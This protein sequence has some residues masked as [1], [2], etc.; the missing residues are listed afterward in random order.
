[1]FTEPTTETQFPGAHTTETPPIAL[2]RAV[3]Y[4]RVSSKGQ[5]DTDYDP[6]GISLPA[7]RAACMRKAEQLGLTVVDEYVEPGKSGTEI[8]KRIAFQT[9]LER[10]RTEKDVDTIVMASLKKRGVTLVSV[11]EN[12]DDSPVGQLMHGI[13]PAFN[14]YRSLEDGAD[15][16]YKMGEKAKKGGTIGAAPLGYLNV[17]ERF[18]GREVRT[19]ALDPE[20]APL[21]KQTF[22]LYATGDYT[23][24]ELCAEMADRAC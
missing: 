15:I 20:R 3:L 16:A 24:D 23:S 6:E 17:V 4:L 22:E 8:S 1:M 12:I 18:E 13:L 19:V 21:I 2:K 11:V 14:E 9:M 10:I 7:Q 5:V